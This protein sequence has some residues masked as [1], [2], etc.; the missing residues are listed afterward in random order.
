MSLDLTYYYRLT[1]YDAFTRAY[2][3]QQVK[4]Y[5]LNGKTC[6]VLDATSGRYGYPG[7]DGNL[8]GEKVAINTVT[9][10]YYYLS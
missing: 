4:S 8:E 1:F 3:G 9:R 10:E 7:Y 2:E 5:R 6:I